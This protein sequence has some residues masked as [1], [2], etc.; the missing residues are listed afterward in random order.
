MAENTSIGTQYQINFINNSSN[1]G[2]FM[3]F[4]QDPNLN[5]PGVSSLAWFTKFVHPNTNGL[6]SWKTGYDFAWM[7]QKALASGITSVTSQCI[8]AD[9]TTNN[10]TL[11]TYDGAYNFMSQPP[12]ASEGTLYI[13]TDHTVPVNQVGVGVGMSGSPCFLVNAQ[14]N[15][16]MVFTPQP[17][18][19]IAFGNYEQG[20]T[21]NIQEMVNSAKL[22]FPE[23]ITAVN[24]TLNPD[25]TWTILPA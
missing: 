6:F 7:E 20:E 11:L 24:V 1:Q 17:E 19:W 15:F 22:D 2:S 16:E 12:V 14:P 21:L 9:F 13:K 10:S 4:Q 3:V 18:Y 23:G 25:N 5:M 8:P